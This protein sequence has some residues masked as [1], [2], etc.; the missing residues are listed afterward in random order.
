MQQYLPPINTPL[1][2]LGQG[3]YKERIVVNKDKFFY[4]EL[5]YSF[6]AIYIIEKKR[7]IISLFDGCW[8]CFLYVSSN[9]RFSLVHHKLMLRFVIFR[10]SLGKFRDFFF[11]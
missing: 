10:S 6:G 11:I 3:K 7:E 2:A 9:F 4:Y 8:I 5:A 1:D